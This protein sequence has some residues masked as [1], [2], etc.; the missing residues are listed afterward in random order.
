MVCLINLLKEY[1]QQH[2]SEPRLL[3]QAPRSRGGAKAW[4]E[5]DCIQVGLV[6]MSFGRTCSRSP[7]K[8]EK[9]KKIINYKNKIHICHTYIGLIGDLLP[10]FVP[11]FCFSPCPFFLEN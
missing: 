9:Q 7:V 2:S 4:L 5:L 11:K 6:C 3:Y 10:E 8:N 1:L